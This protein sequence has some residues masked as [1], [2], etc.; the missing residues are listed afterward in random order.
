MLEEMKKEADGFISRAESGEK[1]T[2]WE[3]DDFLCKIP[4][5]ASKH[6]LKDTGEFLEFLGNPEENMKIIHVAGTNGKGSVCCFI[7]S[8]LMKAGFQV[9]TFTSPHLVRMSERFAVDGKPISDG[10]FV[11]IFIEMLR[12]IKE[13]NECGKEGFFPTYFEFLFFMAMLLL[14]CII[15]E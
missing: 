13:Y 7:T 14:K 9:G 3:C 4:R 1:I 2:I 8:V 11:E 5:F 10:L 6:G 15:M 12:R